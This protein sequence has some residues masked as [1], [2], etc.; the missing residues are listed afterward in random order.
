M[1]LIL[2][3]C[4]GGHLALPDKGAALVSREDG[5]NLLVLPP[6][7]VWERGE[8]TPTEL[9]DWSFLVAAA[10]QAML[11]TLPQ[12]ELGCINYF[13]AGNWA[14]NFAAEPRGPGS[15]GIGSRGIG[16]AGIGSAGIKSGPEHRRVHMH[17]LG[18]SRTAKV[19]Q[20]CRPRSLGCEAQTSER[21]GV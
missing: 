8:L 17:L 4:H 11:R 6:R 20:L 19:S 21:G 15:R 13:E 3:T 7:E 12:L 9:T 16:S 18:R 14:L 1:G 2:F 5:G 10:G